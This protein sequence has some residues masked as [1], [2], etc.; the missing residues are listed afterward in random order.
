MLCLAIDVSG[1]AM[2]GAIME[3]T[4]GRRRCLG[5]FG[6]DTGKNHS[7]GLLPLLDQLLR[8][9]RLDL[10]DVDGFAV[11]AGPGSF[12]GLRIGMAPVQAWRQALDKP[13][14]AVPGLEAMARHMDAGPAA[15]TCPLFD[16]R[17]NEV[18][19]AL[20]RG[21]ER[22][23]EDLAIAPDALIDILLA[24]DE[25]V[26]VGGDGLEVWQEQ[27]QAALGGNFRP[28]PPARC[29]FMAPAVAELGL[30]ALAA[31]RTTPIEAMLPV[32]LRPGV[33]AEVKSGDAAGE[34]GHD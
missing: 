8:Q 10:A 14:V 29:L 27:L 21:Q 20:F 7:L 31:G 34:G 33:D 32:Y 15:L 25:P 19:A 26:Y 12:T 28:L 22:L 16:A 23:S 9:C 24:Y 30:E 17:R 3:D 18:Y 2:S 1:R 11:S 5:Q 6:L 4:G 13:G